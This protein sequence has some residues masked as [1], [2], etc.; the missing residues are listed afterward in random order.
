MTRYLLDTTALIDVSKN[1]EPARSR[2][3]SMIEAGDEL[4]VCGI[5]VAEFYSG[6][7]P[8][9]SAEWDTFLQTL[10]YWQITRA[11]AARAGQD[12]YQFLRQGRTIS[13]TDVL[14]AAVARQQGAV[15]ITNNVKDYPMKDITLL[16]LSDE[17][18]NDQSPT[19][20]R[21]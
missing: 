7:L 9:M 6:V 21:S 5:N 18:T 15:L 3:L 1:R 10:S 13:T 4:G 16:P 20:N 2:I 11:A 12:R 19:K 14:V 8:G 17:A